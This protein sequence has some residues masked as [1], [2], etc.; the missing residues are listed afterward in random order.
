MMLRRSN[1]QDR[2]DLVGTL[3]DPIKTSTTPPSTSIADAKTT[4]PELIRSNSQD[5]LQLVTFKAPVTTTETPAVR[6][7][8]ADMFPPTGTCHSAEISPPLCLNPPSP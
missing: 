2:F 3:P 7:L 5:D 4:P 8:L 1:S 6:L